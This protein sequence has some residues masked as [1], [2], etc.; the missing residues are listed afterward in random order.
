MS[1]KPG[2][3]V[4]HRRLIYAEPISTAAKLLYVYLAER[5]NADSVCWPG[6]DTIARDLS[7]SVSTVGR[8]LTELVT[9]KLIVVESNASDVGTNL[10][11]VYSPDRRADDTD[12]RVGLTDLSTQDR[13][14]MKGHTDRVERSGRPFNVGHTDPQSNYPVGQLPREVEAAAAAVSRNGHSRRPTKLSPAEAATLPSHRIA[15]DPIAGAA[16][17]GIDASDLARWRLL[18][19]DA[20]LDY[21]LVKAADNALNRYEQEPI[22]NAAAFLS[23]WMKGAQRRI[24]EGKQPKGS[25]RAPRPMAET[26]TGMLAL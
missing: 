25:V 7:V 18:A 11:H 2:K 8:A 17:T 6:R 20:D 1:V 3:I 9:A 23:N 10:Y 4:N 14:A 13:D 12:P 21:E 16:F 22:K 26:P 19:P 15:F 24:A 5:A